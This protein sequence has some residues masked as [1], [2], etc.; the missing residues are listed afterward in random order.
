MKDEPRAETGVS[1]P[2]VS[3]PSELQVEVMYR[4]RMM[5]PP[6]AT[7][8]V[9][10]EDTSKMDV[11][12][13]QI[14]NKSMSPQGGPP[15]RITLEYKPSKLDQQGRYTVRA[16]IENE[17]QLMFTS[18]QTYPAFGADGSYGEAAN[19]PVQIMVERVARG[20][21]TND[22]SITGTRWVLKKLGGEDAGLGAGG[23]APDMTLQGAE[24]R[25]SGFA[26]C[27]TMTGRY[28]LEGK[29]LSFSQIAMT[30]K[31][32]LEGMELEQ[33]F[34]KALEATKSHAVAGNQLRL[35]AADGSVL[36][37]LQAE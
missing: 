16:R 15:Y 4:E 21:Q 30:R 24:P 28:E 10:L 35:M 29:S 23:K 27:N 2:G 19:E 34:A 1:P 8:E 3:A 31:A 7:L 11:A 36:A 20:A 33:E 32:C 22:A 14:A 26:G 9:T 5:L 12:A 6:T 18:T 37:E 17:G 25:V 13:E